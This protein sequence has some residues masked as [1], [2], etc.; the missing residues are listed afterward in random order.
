MYINTCVYAGG[1]IAIIELRNTNIIGNETASFD[2]SEFSRAFHASA[3][4]WRDQQPKHYLT[5]NLI[6][7]KIF[8]KKYSNFSV[9]NYNWQPRIPLSLPNRRHHGVK[10]QR[11]VHRPVQARV[12]KLKIV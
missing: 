9:R 5:P 1:V 11:Q 6:T 3:I 12:M 2:E 7:H 8:E 10:E 4:P